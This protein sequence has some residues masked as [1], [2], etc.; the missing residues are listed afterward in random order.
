[1]GTVRFPPHLPPSSRSWRRAA[2]VLL[3]LLVA[4][5]QAGRAADPVTYAVTLAP[6]GVAELDAALPDLS[7]L[8]TLR[9]SAPVGPSALVARARADSERIT[10]A[11]HSLGHYAGTVSVRIDGMPADALGVVE[12]LDALPD[13]TPVAVQVDVTPGP[14]FPLRRVDLRGPV[15]PEARRAFPLAPG[16]PARADAILGAR[17]TLR[18]A[19]RAEG[20][21]LAEVS[22]PDA[23]LY[24]EAQAVDVAYTARPG[25][26]VDIGAIRI[27][28]LERLNES[29]VRRRL[30]LKPG[31]RFDPARIE[32]AR[33]DLASLPVLA[34]VRITEGEVLG[35]DGRLPIEVDVAERKRRLIELS[36]AWSTDQGGRL[37]AQWSHRNL[38]GNAEQLTLS[39]AVTDLGGT[40]VQSPGYNLNARLVLPEFFARDQALAL[41]GFARRAYLNAYDI[42]AVGGSAVLSRKLPEDWLGKGWTVSAGLAG[43]QS[44][45]VQEGVTSHY[46]LLQVPLE[47]LLDTTD[48]LLDPTRGVRANLSVTPTVDV[49]PEQVPPF[50]IVQAAA[51][52][53]LDLSE[54]LGQAPGRSVLALR[55]LVGVVSGGSAGDLPPDQRFY[56]GGTA[57]IRGYRFQSV[58]PQFPSGNPA[59]G[60]SISTGTVEWRQRIGES[61]GAAVFVDAG[62]VGTD[63]IP[64]TGDLRVGAGVGVRYYTAIGPIRADFAV[65]LISQKGSDAF[66]LYLGIGQ[67]F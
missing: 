32:A 11:L 7:L 46:T 3:A 54:A 52:T 13:G 55:A 36:A 59:G 56:A 64:F 24:P 45:I 25:P 29:F 66:Q 17:E 60:N 12:R 61:W 51:S 38:F 41:N 14:V 20:H 33:R 4:G 28:G 1:M 35:P 47:V 63:G 67:A 62:Q 8:Q 19:L 2:M 9:E 50:T 43:Q 23:V 65:P 58:G 18:G 31:E 21:A 15:P 37:S 6:S 26:V 53:Y 40:A 39:A 49:G 48:S 10:A 5:S 44:R 16:Q 34:S 30:M 57:T 27:A 22:P 42:D